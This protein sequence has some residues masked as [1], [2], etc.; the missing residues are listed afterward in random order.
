[1]SEIFPDLYMEPVTEH[2]SFWRSTLDEEY[3][4]FTTKTATS[5]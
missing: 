1:L 2:I 3:Y 4:A 5:V